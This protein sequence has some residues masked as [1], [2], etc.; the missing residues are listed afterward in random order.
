[1]DKMDFVRRERGEVSEIRMYLDLYLNGAQIPGFL[2]G[3]QRSTLW[4]PTSG[5][6]PPY[7]SDIS[8]WGSVSVTSKAL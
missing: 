6:H 2:S 5:K 3:R 7:I 8:C 1:M 4:Q